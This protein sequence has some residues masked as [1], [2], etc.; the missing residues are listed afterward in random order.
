MKKRAYKATKIKKL[1][2]AKLKTEIEGKAIVIGVDV[3][4]EDF[5]ATIMATDRK[6]IETIRWKHPS[7]SEIFL[8][9]I[10]KELRWNSLEV[11]MEP[12]GTYGDCLRAQLLGQG[13]AVYRVSPKRT[14]DA[15]EVYDGV[16]S[17]H[18]AKAAAIIARLH[19]DASSEEWPMPEDVQRELT[20]VIKTMEIFDDAYQR[21]INRLEALTMRYWPELTQYLQLQSATL[22]ELLIEYGSPQQVDQVAQDAKK[23]MKRAGGSLLAESKIGAV[24]E[25]ARNT[26]GV[27][28]IES[29]RVQVQELSKETRRLQK[30]RRRVK[31]KVEELTTDNESVRKMAPVVGKVTSAVLY[32]VLGSMEEYDNAASVVKSL[33]LNLK[34]RSSGKHKGQLRITKRGSGLARMYLYMATLRLIQKDSIIKAWY[35]KKLS[36]DGKVKKKALVAIMRKLASALWHVGRGSKFDASKLFDVS[37]LAV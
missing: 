23:L 7:E 10:L 8:D 24:L 20:A 15:A 13:I 26:L 4:K 17:M 22:L 3:A 28:C 30:E 37:R 19:L 14:H 36:R 27:V 18:D 16:P 12:S 9:V 29:E 25:S 21:N 1:N 6:V 35:Q 33:G 31:L 32:M 11:A 34:E 5:M 2:L